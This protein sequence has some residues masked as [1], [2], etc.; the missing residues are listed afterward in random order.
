MSTPLTTPQI[1]SLIPGGWQPTP[2]TTPGVEK[3]AATPVATTPRPIET[4]IPDTTGEKTPVPTERTNIPFFATV[5]QGE[6]T[7]QN[8]RQDTQ[9]SPFFGTSE[10]Q[11]A[12]EIP[13]VQE[14]RTVPTP[15][16]QKESHTGRN[17][18]AGAVVGAGA[19]AA[20]HEAYEKHQEPTS[21][22]IKPE[23]ERSIPQEQAALVPEQT[24]QAPRE[25]RKEEKPQSEK[26]IEKPKKQKIDYFALRKTQ[27]PEPEKQLATPVPVTTSNEASGSTVAPQTSDFKEEEL[28]NSV[29]PL[30]KVPTSRSVGRQ[31]T[32]DQLLKTL[33]R[34]RTSVSGAGLSDDG[35]ENAE[36]ERLISTMFGTARQQASEEEQTRHKGVIFKNLSVIGEGLGAAIQPTVASLFY[37]PFLAIGNLLRGNGRTQKRTL[38]DDFTG[39]I[40]PKEMLLVLGRPGSGCSTFLKVLANQRKGFVAVNGDVVYGGTSAKDMAKNYRGEILYNPEDDLHYASITVKHTLQFAIRTRTPPKS[41]RQ[42]GETRKDY[43]S[44]FLRMISKVLWIEHTMNTKVGNSLIRGVSGGEKKRVSIGEAMV[45]KASV[46]A[47][48]NSSKGLDASSALEY[49]SSIRALTN[50]TGVSTA[51]ALYQAGQSLYDLFDKVLL[52]DEGK[53]CY[54]GST[55]TANAYFENLGFECPGR[56][57]TSDF[58]TSVT[59]LNERRIRKGWEDRV[60]RTAT[61]FQRAYLESDERKRVEAEIKDF[62]VELQEQVRLREQNKSKDTKRRNFTVSFPEQVRACTVRQFR[63]LL[64]DPLSLYGKWGGIIFQALIVGSL[65]YNTPVNAAGAFPRGGV[66]FFVILFNTFLALAELPSSFVA[67]PIMLKHRSFSF[68]RPSAFAIA[69]VMVDIP[70]VVVQVL[71]FNII[72]YWMSGLQRTASHFFINCLVTY[73]NTVAMYSFFRMMGAWNKNLDNAT[74]IVGVAI[75]A[76]IVYTGYLIPPGSQ[77]PWLH[78]LTYI[79]PLSYG[80]EALMANEFDGLSLECVPPYLVPSYG[81]PPFQSCALSGSEPGNAFV[82]GSQYISVSFDYTR[83]HLW[84]NVGIGVG[85][86]LFFV[87]MTMIGMELQTPNKGGAAITIF[88][89]G[90]APKAIE[91][92]MKKGKAT[93]DEEKGG[94]QEKINLEN[95]SGHASNGAAPEG[96][97]KNETIFTW[98]NV[99]YTIP[100]KNGSTRL[101]Q[102][103]SGIVRP[104]RLTALMGASGAGKTTLLNAL[105]QRLNFGTVTGTFLVDGRP[106]PKSFQR[107][108]GFAEQQDIH[109]P[110]QTVREAMQFSALLRQPKEVPTKEKYEY[111]EKILSLLEM[112]DIAGA[113]VG[114][115]GTGLNAEQKKR[116]TIA[117]E[118]ASKPELLIF[119][120]EPTSGLDSGAAFNIVRFLRKLAEAGQ[121]VLCTIHQPSAVL[122]EEFDDLILLKSGGRVVYHGELG[123]DSRKMI[124]YFE[125]NGAK[126]CKPSQ[127]PAEYMLE[128]IGAGNPNYKGKDFGDVWADSQEHHDR[129]GEIENAINERKDQPAAHINDNR[130]YAMPLTAQVRAMLVRTFRAYWRDTDYVLGKVILHIV[131]A[132]FNSLTFW[133]LGNSRVDMQSRLFSVF[134]T[135]TI[136]PPLINQL[137]PKFIKLRDI[138]KSRES[139]AKIYSWFAFVFSAVVVEIPYAFVSGTIYMMCWY[140]IIGFNRDS[141]V[142]AYVWFLL[143]IFEVYFIS[144]GQAIASFSPNEMLA[145]LLVPVFFLFVVSFAGI[146]V[147]YAGLPTFW[148]SWMYHLSPFRYLLEG[149]LGILTHDVRVICKDNEFAN[150]QTPNGQTCQEYTQ[151]FI[152]TVGGYVDT[153]PDGSCNYCQYSVGDEYAAS[154][155]SFYSHRWRDVYVSIAFC[156]FN[157]LVI[158]VCSWLYLQGG[159]R[160]KNA[161]GR[162]KPKSTQSRDIKNSAT[163]SGEENYRNLE[164]QN[165]GGT[166]GQTEVSRVDSKSGRAKL[167]KKNRPLS[168]ASYGGDG[169]E[170]EKDHEGSPNTS[171]R[172]TGDEGIK[173]AKDLV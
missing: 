95:G 24:T 75:Q 10:G 39:L 134:M 150:Y 51:V 91:N 22:P 103:V 18:V 30:Y 160:I 20:A 6:T 113:V 116:L 142:V 88:K 58:L 44:N 93:A 146:V 15:E 161:F 141:G 136:A 67:R 97:A 74:K 159:R 84:R 101:L 126:K 170:S 104:G 12:G 152:D 38:I 158:F 28:E 73:I 96:I 89:R 35:E 130:E 62:E 9:V 82:D 162:N 147:P 127:N 102:D 14:Q 165:L 157:I 118:L 5:P 164:D 111:V 13:E 1:D 64:G 80:F 169:G 110:T 163:P 85:F 145:S 29:S 121:A 120:D 33:S 77:H 131:T 107:A 98:Q 57:T 154:F 23:P 100:T 56:W 31:Y 71:L 26:K 112:E 92:A 173:D 66:L 86:W 153:A 138:Y 167:Q 11:Q 63:V 69:Q 140:W 72:V 135:L 76:V 60:P 149:F 114:E 70:S 124:E 47:W 119:L 172:G 3:G 2:I 65:F 90:G 83:T 133:K 48:D 81:Q 34:R 7:S 156:V 46:Q 87:A 53:C 4:D 17:V 99:N 117:V 129:M 171:R 55:E 94:S 37:G 132:F 40:K 50:M 137:Q 108:T 42:E 27:T 52:I 166:S 49:V 105:A 109:E 125:G 123:K 139:N 115:I 54:F 21:V 79:N 68:Y 19:A 122:F 59:D 151:R 128:A 155:N 41:S 143:M 144:F 168:M 61:E 8:G 32:E 148:R 36:L 25:Q 43:V 106:L 78:W 16:A 45:T